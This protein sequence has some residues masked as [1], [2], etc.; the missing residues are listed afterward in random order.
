MIMRMKE[1]SPIKESL[2]CQKNSPCQHL[3]KCIKNS[4]KT[5]HTNIRV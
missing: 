2:D 1:W 3:R 5:M 4:M